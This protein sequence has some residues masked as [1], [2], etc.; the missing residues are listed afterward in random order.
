L[1]AVAAIA[2]LAAWV[3]VRPAQATDWRGPYDQDAGRYYSDEARDYRQLGFDADGT[4]PARV[5]RPYYGGGVYLPSYPYAA[6][7]SDSYYYGAYSQSPPARDNAARI[8]L[9]VPADAKVW[10]DSKAT[11]QSGSER[12]FE[13]PRLAPGREYSYDVKAQWRDANGKD[14]TRT[15][16]VGV[17]ANSNVTVDFTRPASDSQGK[18]GSSSR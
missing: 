2:A 17:S 4:G 6:E 5:Y 1:V 8:R 7:T 18:S 13:S 11:V 9:V 15:R 12:N 16:Q 3:G 10:F 14:V